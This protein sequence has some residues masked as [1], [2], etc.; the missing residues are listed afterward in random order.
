MATLSLIDDE[1]AAQGS[2]TVGEG[3]VAV[4]REDAD[5]LIGDES[6]SRRHF[7][8]VR[9]AEGYLIQDL[10]SANGTWVDGKRVVATRLRATECIVAGRC[11][12]MFMQ[13]PG[14]SVVDPG[15]QPQA[16]V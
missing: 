6:L 7:V 15:A 16:V 2:W 1:G 3:A 11:V 8:I 10:Q 13:T 12:F 5:V 4:G 9:D 14:V